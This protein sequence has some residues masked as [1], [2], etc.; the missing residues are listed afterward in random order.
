MSSKKVVVEDYPLFKES[1]AAYGAKS[2]GDRIREHFDWSLGKRYEWGSWAVLQRVAY[3]D[4]TH[5]YLT[6]DFGLVNLATTTSEVR[7]WIGEERQM[8]S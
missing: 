7:V 6:D 1:D 8:V 3:V 4:R 5:V 2:V